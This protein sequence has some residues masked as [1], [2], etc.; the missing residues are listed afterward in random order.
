MTVVGWNFLK[1]GLFSRSSLSESEK[2][3]ASLG[4]IKVLHVQNH[5]SSVSGSCSTSPPQLGHLSIEATLTIAFPCFP[6]PAYFPFSIFHFPFRDSVTA[7][8]HLSQ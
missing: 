1:S 6:K 4:S 8:K 7:S 5:V 2:S 3:S